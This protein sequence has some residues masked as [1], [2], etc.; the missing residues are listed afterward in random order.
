[1]SPL[2]EQRKLD[3]APQPNKTKQIKTRVYKGG[4][5]RGER[6]IYS[7]AIPIIMAI[8][9]MVISNYASI[10]SLN[11]DQQSTQTSIVQQ[12]SLNDGL[13][14]QVKELSD[15]DRILSI[16]QTDLGMT[17]ND[18]QVRVLHQAD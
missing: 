2:M 3:T 7:L 8:G 13:N 16:A 15:P 1:M 4:V 9:F 12:E 11:A 5:T 10:Y 6:L 17:L 14:L 18:E